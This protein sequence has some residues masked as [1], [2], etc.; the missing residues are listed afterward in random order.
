MGEIVDEEG[1]PGETLLGIERELAVVASV[2]SR[3]EAS[4][5]ALHY[6]L[7][8]MRVRVVYLR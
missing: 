2:V 8:R 6:S 1:D 5:L 4:Q 7:Q 3:A